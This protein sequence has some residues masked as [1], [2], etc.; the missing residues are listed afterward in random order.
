MG[1][2]YT[3]QVDDI[4]V[5]MIWKTHCIDNSLLWNESIQSLFWY[6]VDYIPHCDNNGMIFNPDEFNFAEN[7]VELAEF[8]I[9]TDGMKP[10]KK[11]TEVIIQF[12][13]L[14]NLTG[15][16]SWFGLVNQVSCAF[17]QAEIM[18]PL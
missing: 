13:T 17:S 4:T 14:I 8:M 7:E 6:T 3:H 16:R 15:I 12:P 11:I 18:P 2:L 1:D 9:I 5:D 10:T